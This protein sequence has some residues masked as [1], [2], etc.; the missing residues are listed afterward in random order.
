MDPVCF[1]G[2]I[3]LENFW[4]EIKKMRTLKKVTIYHKKQVST[5]VKRIWV[6][7]KVGLSKTRRQPRLKDSIW[8]VFWWILI[9]YGFF[10]IFYKSADETK[11]ISM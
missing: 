10:D 11:K 3:M 5:D 4:S 7:F 1:L 6:Q 2:R 9:L 8:K